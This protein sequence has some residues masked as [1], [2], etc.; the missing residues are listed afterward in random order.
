MVNA[1]R[2]SAEDEDASGHDTLLGKYSVRAASRGCDLEETLAIRTRTE[3]EP[4]SCS[5]SSYSGISA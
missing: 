3:D 4:L 5:S 2:E 1:E